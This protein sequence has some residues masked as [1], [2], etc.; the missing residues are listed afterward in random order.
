MGSVKP[1]PA[2][3][4]SGCGRRIGK[5]ALHLVLADELMVICGRC[6]VEKSRATHAGIFPDCRE[7]GH[8]L[9]DHHP[10]HATRAG[11]ARLLGLWP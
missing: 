1:A 7:R 8:D 5:T 4:C 9:L 3:D 11:A 6:G 10:S 2:L